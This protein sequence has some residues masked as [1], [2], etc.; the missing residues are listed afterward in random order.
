MEIRS[1]SNQS[2]YNVRQTS[3]MKKNEDMEIKEV[4]TG[5]TLNKHQ[6]LTVSPNLSPKAWPDPGFTKMEPILFKDSTCVIDCMLQRKGMVIHV[7]L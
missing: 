1:Y 4:N 6:V 3:V 5:K 2:T 7:K